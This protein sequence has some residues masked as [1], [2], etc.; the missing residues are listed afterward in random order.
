MRT[1]A[2]G[3]GLRF[4]GHPLRQ[5][6]PCFSEISLSEI[7]AKVPR[8]SLAKVGASGPRERSLEIAGAF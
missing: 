1:E 4:C 6:I 3:T 2:I 5:L 8:V 7:V